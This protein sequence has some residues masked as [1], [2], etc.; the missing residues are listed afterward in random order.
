MSRMDPILGKQL[1]GNQWLDGEGT[2]WLSES[3][4]DANPV[5]QGRFA[6]PN[7]VRAAIS[8]AQDAFMDWCESPVQHRMDICRNFA[9]WVSNNRQALSTLICH[10]TG[11]P[12]WEADA[13]V[14]TVIDKVANSID[15]L[16]ARRW[17]TSVN[18]GT[19]LAVTRFRPHGVLL[20]LG[21]FNLPAH[22]PGSHIVPALLAGN[23]IAFKPSELTP[24]VGQ[25]L[26]RAWQHAGLPAG[27][28][29]LI[30]GDAAVAQVAVTDDRIAGVLFTGSRRAGEQLHRMFAGR[31]DKVLAL[32][33]GGNNPLV[34]HRTHDLDLAAISVIQSAY[35]TSGQRCTCAR[36]LIVTKEAQPD[37]FICRLQQLVTKI[38]VG[39]S[40][41]QPQPFMGP[42][43][44]PQQA[45]KMLDSLEMV[46]QSGAQ[47]L[48]RMELIPPNQSLLTPGLLDATGISLEDDEH[49]GPLLVIQRTGSLDEAID[50]ANQTQYGLA[51]GLISDDEQ[52]FQHFLRR[53]HAGVVNWNRPT[54]GASGRLPFG[55]IG[56]SGNHQ[57]SGF[58]AAD[59]CSFPVASLECRDLN[60]TRKLLPGL[61]EV[62]QACSLK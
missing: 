47:S 6:G 26:A 19:A 43:I 41:D 42:V 9:N 10:E 3:Q 2:D 7:Q 16:L 30:H 36:R 14:G 15:A 4:V 35:I 57:P 60:D 54:T 62:G 32:E 31:P 61:D 58:F 46:L 29:N 51:A 24:G 17:T 55:G 59:Y 28:L 34:V 13:E 50:L 33:M 27:V 39:R 5:W 1:I 48:C 20:V 23:T 52:D 18:Q 22:L 45:Q 25:W 21:P 37:R 56:R 11:K 44:R 53:I 12:Q 38:R 49:F 40:F 8:A